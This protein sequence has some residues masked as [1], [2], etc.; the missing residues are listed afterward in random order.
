MKLDKSIDH[1]FQGLNLKKLFDS[2]YLKIS[3]FLT[4]R[5]TRMEISIKRKFRIFLYVKVIFLFGY[6]NLL[7]EHIVETENYNWKTIL[8]K[9]KLKNGTVWKFQHFEKLSTMGQSFKLFFYSKIP[10]VWNNSIA[11]IQKT[12]KEKID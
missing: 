12:N 10:I 11:K 6:F 7:T 1:I 8:K 9:K 2:F 4:N 5:I 3:I